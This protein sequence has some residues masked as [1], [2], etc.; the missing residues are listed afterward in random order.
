MPRSRQWQHS[1]GACHTQLEIGERPCTTRQEGGQREGRIFSPVS[2][3]PF[4]R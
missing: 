4:S 3:Y 1:E 2:G